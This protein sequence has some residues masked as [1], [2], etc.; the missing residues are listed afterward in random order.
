LPAIQPEPDNAGMTS[1]RPRLAILLAAAVLGGCAVVPVQ[2]YGYD[3]VPAATVY[4]APPQ[5][6][7]EYRGLPPALGYVWL[8]GYWN[9]AGVRYDWIPGRWIN[10]PPGRVWVPRVWRRDGDR[11]HSHG[12][13]WEPH[14][15]VQRLAPQPVWPRRDLH[16][17]SE[18]QPWPRP[19]AHS[20]P[21]RTQRPEHPHELR[22]QA[23]RDGVP[24][25]APPVS[26]APSGF[27]RRAEHHSFRPDEPTRL[28]P[29][30]RQQHP[31]PA[32]AEAAPS[33]RRPEDG[34]RFGRHRPDDREPGERRPSQP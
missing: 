5:P 15:Q 30:A 9:W 21:A 18:P 33:Q 29:Q 34:R 13:F 8:D 12:G 1:L 31:V 23:S 25:S 14:R 7:V 16:G 4:A 2:D 26:P 3:P 17:H 22:H 6:L 32:P 11:W 28:P 10:P 24:N 20:F 19:D 27:L